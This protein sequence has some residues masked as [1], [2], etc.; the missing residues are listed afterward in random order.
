MCG[1]EQTDRGDKEVLREGE[2]DEGRER[3]RERAVKSLN[4]LHL[5]KR[6]RDQTKSLEP[7]HS[8]MNHVCEQVYR[9]TNTE[10]DCE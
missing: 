2:K 1:M 4:R 7:L 10:N 3:D 5:K 8:G 9:C 6:E